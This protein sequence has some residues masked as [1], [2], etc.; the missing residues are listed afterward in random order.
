MEKDV[1]PAPQR[2]MVLVSVQEGLEPPRWLGRVHPF[3]MAVLDRLEF[4]GWELSVMFC[5]DGFIRRLN[6]R[7]RGI[8]IPTDVLSFEQ[9]GT[10][11]D[12]S[13]RKWFSAGDIVISVDTLARNAREFSV[14]QD[15]ELK[16]LL[17]H[18]VLH[19]A[20]HD[21]SDNSPG[22]EMLKMQESILSSFLDKADTI[23]EEQ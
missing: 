9:G 8:D 7:Y 4:S 1:S 10:Y 6:G 3:V 21:H 19:L 11:E 13:G 2:N 5:D 15:E 22:Q 12:D 18:G 23:I 14:A 17:V 20:G 16:R